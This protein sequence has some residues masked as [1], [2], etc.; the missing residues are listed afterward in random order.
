MDGSFPHSD[1]P[2]QPL[3]RSHRWRPSSPDG[4]CWLFRSLSGPGARGGRFDLPSPKGTCYWASTALSAA[5]ERLGR[6][7]DLVA[8]DETDGVVVSRARVGRGVAADLLD[9]DAARRGAIAELSATTDYPLCQRWAASFVAAG[10]D[11]VRYQPRFSSDRAYA[12]ALFGD[13]GVPSSAPAV[14]DSVLV[15]DIW[16]AHGYTIVPTPR[17]EDLGP[18]L[19]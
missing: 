12:L 8:E 15:R 11:G 14:T 4:G 19:D 16:I 1:F 18:L 5:R 13:E 3:Y 2:S 7:G 10:F 17:A 6:P 9:V